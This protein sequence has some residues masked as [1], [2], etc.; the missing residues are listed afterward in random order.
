[1]KDSMKD[2]LSSSWDLL[3]TILAGT[4]LFLIATLFGMRLLEHVVC[5]LLRLGIVRA[6]AGIVYGLFSSSSYFLMLA[7]VALLSL[8]LS[9]A[10]LHWRSHRPHTT[11]DGTERR[12]LG[13]SAYTALFLSFIPFVGFGLS[14]GFC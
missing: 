14:I 5:V 8:G 7:V 13:F 3:K 10:Y 6:D 2:S 11:P 1:M 12:F 4:L 9:C